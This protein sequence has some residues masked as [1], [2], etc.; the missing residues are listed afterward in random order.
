MANAVVVERGQS[1]SSSPVGRG[2]TH[3]IRPPR[4]SGRISSGTTLPGTNSDPAGRCHSL[5]AGPRRR[6]R[7][8]RPAPEGDRRGGRAS[9]RPRHPPGPPP[10]PPGTSA[11]GPGGGTT[12]PARYGP[13]RV[14]TD[15][16]DPRRD[17]DHADPRGGAARTRSGT[18]GTCG[19]ILPDGR[20]IPP[21]AVRP[22]MDGGARRAGSAPRVARR[23]GARARTASRTQPGRR[24]GRAYRRSARGRSGGRVRP[25]AHAGRTD[26]AP[27]DAPPPL[28]RARAAIRSTV[29]GRWDGGRSPAGG[30]RMR[31]ASGRS[32]RSRSGRTRRLGIS[33][34]PD[35]WPG[36]IAGSPS[37]ARG[38]DAGRTPIS[39]RPP[40][41]AARTRAVGRPDRA[42]HRGRRNAA[43]SV[44]RAMDRLGG[45]QFP[46]V[47]TGPQ[48]ALRGDRP[49]L[50]GPDPD[51]AGNVVVPRRRE[52]ND[53]LPHRGPR[54]SRGPSV[55]P[56]TQPATV[57][58]AARA[59]GALAQCPSDPGRC[60]IAARDRPVLSSRGR[61]LRG[62]RPT[63][64][65]GDPPAVRRAR[66][67][68]R[69][70]CRVARAQDLEHG[71]G[72]RCAR[73]PRGRRA[74]AP[75]G[76]RPR[77]VGPTRPVPQGALLRRGT[78]GP[79]LFGPG[80]VR[81]ATASP[82]PRP[83]RRRP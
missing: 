72:A 56:R 9:R 63:R 3:R 26:S 64:P 60:E 1:L 46:F 12:V 76:G 24:R 48:Q 7:R 70:G 2:S 61:Y 14:G 40:I 15:V 66:A 27:R 50:E 13:P 52:W 17:P 68:W 21:G 80:A 67:R 10:G 32:P 45:T 5:P 78:A 42:V 22:R 55:R 57:R 59:R 11:V 20:R 82:G 8:H 62:R 41:A 81:P 16:A 36:A 83:V 69:G 43:A 23:A 4:G 29:P 6:Q 77:S 79:A 31:A 73:T 34:R 28:S 58:A 25:R 37:W 53:R 74:G 35:S 30:E 51:R 38:T 71:T 18:R 47:R 49:R 39:P 54:R 75:V 33:S 44:R 19:R 65:G